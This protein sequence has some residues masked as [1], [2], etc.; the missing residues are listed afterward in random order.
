MKSVETADSPRRG[1]AEHQAAQNPATVR[2]AG[3][4]GP[5]PLARVGRD[6][7]A[8]MQDEP[9][10]LETVRHQ[11]AASKLRQALAGFGPTVRQCII[12]RL[13]RGMS[14]PEIAG[15]LGLSREAVA[16][17]LAGARSRVMS[18]TNFFADDWYWQD[19]DPA[20]AGAG[21]PGAAGKG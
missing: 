18:Y 15:S 14:F 2:R 21:E 6:P 10:V 1:A 7:L 8:S 4:R 13:A 9:S 17:V 5:L 20:D 3:R 16:E 11:A 12:A 19:P